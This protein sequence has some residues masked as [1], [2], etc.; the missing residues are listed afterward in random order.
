MLEVLNSR[1]VIMTRG[2]QLMHHQKG[3]VIKR[4]VDSTTS[5]QADTTSGKTDITSGQTSTT[6]EETSTTSE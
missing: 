2:K 4:P 3:S 6:R 1:H 5:G